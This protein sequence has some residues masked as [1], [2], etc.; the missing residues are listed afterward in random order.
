MKFPHAVAGTPNLDPIFQ[1]NDAEYLTGVKV[2]IHFSAS[3][4]VLDLASLERFVTGVPPDGVDSD[5]SDD[6][7][8]FKFAPSVQTCHGEATDGLSATLTPPL[9]PLKDAGVRAVRSTRVGVTASEHGVRLDGPTSAQIRRAARA[10]ESKEGLVGIAK[11]AT[12]E[13]WDRIG[14]ERAFPPRP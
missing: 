9:N 5:V 11:V 10:F 12:N 14:F 7:L 3:P 8:L 13:C 1:V 4:P 6:W 2:N